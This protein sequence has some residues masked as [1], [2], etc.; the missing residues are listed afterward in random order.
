ESKGAFTGEVSAALLAD[1]GCKYVIVGH[2]ERRQLFG[3]TDATVQRKV[4]AGLDAGLVVI[5]CIGETERERDAGQTLEVVSTQL[6][7][8]L[9]SVSGAE[10]A[11]LI[12]AYEPVWA[13]GTGRTA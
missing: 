8:G 11:G 13:I 1:A 2:S 5:L 12:V 9:S 10:A 6:S 3:E 4:R 7:A